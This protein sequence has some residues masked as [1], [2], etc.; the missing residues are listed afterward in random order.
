M[1]ATQHYTLLW[2]CPLGQHE[3]WPQR[4]CAREARTTL[5]GK[6]R[7]HACA[8]G[9]LLLIHVYGSCTD[10]FLIFS[11]KNRRA[12]FAAKRGIIY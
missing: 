8:L 1:G 3:G 10:A 9:D 7:K 6:K 5:E 11:S 12:V 4:W 2:G